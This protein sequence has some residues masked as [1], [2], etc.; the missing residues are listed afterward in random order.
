VTRRSDRAQRTADALADAA[1]ELI[2]EHGY[3]QTT[4]EDIASAAGVTPR[5]FFRHFESKAAALFARPDR[6]VRQRFAEA[7]EDR[8]DDEPL[9][10]ALRAAMRVAAAAVDDRRNWMF[11]IAR[12]ASDVPEIR[13][14]LESGFG[15]AGREVI[16]SWAERRIGAPSVVDPRPQLLAGIAAACADAA[17]L[18]FLA[19]AGSLDAAA[20]LEESFDH[21][22]DLLDT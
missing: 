7:L 3:R 15:D 2:R 19:H 8:P 14:H 1:R 16:V 11:E 4:I 18:R 9:L 22:A 20:L 5:T 10:D 17:I 13:E 12:L 21:L 6:E